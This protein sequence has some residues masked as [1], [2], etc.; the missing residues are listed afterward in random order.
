[1]KAITLFAIAL[2]TLLAQHI[3]AEQPPITL[4][5][6]DARYEFQLTLADGQIRYA[7]TFDHHPVIL[8]S[9]LGIE[10]GRRWND[11]LQWG[12]IS[13]SETDTLW[14]PVYGERNTIRD[15]YASCEIEL[16]QGETRLMIDVRAY[17]EG[18]AFRYRFP[19]NSYLRIDAELTEFTMPEQTKAYFTPWAQTAYQLL[20]LA[21]WPSESDRP[22]LL[23]L[24]NHDYA[25]LT[26]AA[27]SDYV[28]TKF[29]LS[30]THANTICTSMYGPVED[31]APFATPW[32]VIMCG[33]QA[34]DILQHNDLLLNL[35]PPC[36]IEDT[37]WIKPGKAMREISLDTEKAKSLVDFAVEHNIQ[38]IHF[39]AGWYGNE[40]DRT[41]D[42]TTVTVDPKRNPHP[43]PLNL[44]EAIAYAKSKGVGVFLYVNQRALQQQLHQILPLYK[45]WGVA[46]IKFGFVQVG[47]HA[48]TRWMH[49]AVKMCADYQLM[50]DIHDEYRPT[51]FS[52]TYPNLLTQE[53]IRGNEEFPDATHNATLPFTRFV[54][55]A[56]DYTICYYS[57]D[58]NRLANGLPIDPAE[59]RRILRTTPAHQLALSVVYY[60]P[61]QFVYWYDNP[62]RSQNEPEMKFFDDVY[63]VWDDTRI[64]NGEVG[65]YITTARR[66]DNEWFIGAITGNIGR[67]HDINLSFLQPSMKYQ[68][69][70]YTDGDPSIPTRTKVKVETM[71][72]SSKS[73]L[74]FELK[75]SGGVAIRLTPMN[76]TCSR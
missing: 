15:H 4:L 60:S 11:N 25:S 16:R 35:N 19:G 31:I 49:E 6:P 65:K 68:A 17:N 64:L 72:V 44:P 42:A 3:Q 74:H 62:S 1:M 61:L 67:Q 21:N 58:F 24:P 8:P 30:P 63:T 45:S 37:S 12:K 23:E 66:H 38:Y 55:G 36:K 56:A 10:A 41:S 28:R 27:V 9:Q 40:Y 70:I 2:F 75:P 46:G 13:K 51:G 57:Q 73:T 26:E 29:S 18:V 22:L 71:E 5:S 48:W 7:L 39:D 69:E 43:N 54:A 59:T 20:P 32:R 33:H 50:V 52:R 34:T 53:G 47:S 14:H 76:A